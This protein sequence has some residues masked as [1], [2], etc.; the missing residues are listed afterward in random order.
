MAR[1]PALG[2]NPGEYSRQIAATLHYLLRNFT[3][4]Q[5]NDQPCTIIIIIIIIIIRIIIRIIVLCLLHTYTFAQ[6]TLYRGPVLRQQDFLKFIFI[7]D[8][9]RTEPEP[10]EPN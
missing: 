3:N 1:A 8:G 9:N 7:R 6:F 2:M 5:S 10:N 4:N